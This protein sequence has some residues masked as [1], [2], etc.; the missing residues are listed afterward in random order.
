MSET[1][2]KRIL[3]AIKDRIDGLER[4]IAVNRRLLNDE[5]VRA[6]ETS[7]REHALALN[8]LERSRALLIRNRL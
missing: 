7:L 8:E 2:Y 4:K 3:V 5:L 6:F 1:S